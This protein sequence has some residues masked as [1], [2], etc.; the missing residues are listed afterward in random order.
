MFLEDN[1]I[2]LREMIHTMW[3][4]LYV[5]IDSLTFIQKAAKLFSLK[6]QVKSTKLR[7]TFT[8]KVAKIYFL[9]VADLGGGRPWGPNSFNFIQLFGKFGKIVCWP[10]PSPRRVGA[11][12]GGNYRFTTA[13][14]S[15]SLMHR[16][17]SRTNIDL[18]HCSGRY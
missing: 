15:V 2:F 4:K 3:E 17:L 1:C 13:L 12:L 11:R 5:A 8:T 10:P 18:G 16:P 14:V 6:E 9:T 7:D